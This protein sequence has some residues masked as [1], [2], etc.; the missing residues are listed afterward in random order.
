M[1]VK[2]FVATPMYGGMCYGSY[3]KSMCD[4]FTLC[5]KHNIPIHQEFVFNESLI[6]R[7]RNACV[8]V[9]LQSNCTHF[10]FVDADVGFNGKDVLTMLAMLVKDK[11]EK[12]DV[13]AGVYPKKCVNWERIKQKK[14]FSQPAKE[15]AK[16]GNEYTLNPI[17][18]KSITFQKGVPLEVSDAGTGFMMIPRRTFDKFKE[19]YPEQSYTTY[20]TYNSSE[21]S[22]KTVHAFF[23]S[24]I[25][26]ETNLYLA[27]DYMFCHYVRKMG[28]KVWILPWINLSHTGSYCY[29]G[30]LTESAALFS[31]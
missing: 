17:D 13:L 18:Q 27:E 24:K 25:D 11:E 2:L 4:L 5:A 7:A 20:K 28:G 3:T 26:P 29:S 15:L 22:P 12:Y 8:D 31:F 6:Q 23:D 19:A 16:L 9:F 21:K 30:S 10:F 14:D 1:D